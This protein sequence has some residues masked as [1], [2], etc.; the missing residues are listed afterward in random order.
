MNK[1]KFITFEG[2]EGAGKTTQI[3][4]LQQKL[5]N[6]GVQI[7]VTREP[8]G[9][10]SAE[11]LR[12]LVV[13][14]D[15]DDWSAMAELLIITAGRY[16]HVQNLILPALE[17]GVWV[18]SDRFYDSSAVYQGIAGGLGLEKVRRIQQEVLGNFAPDLTLVFDLPPA[19]GLARAGK[20]EADT[21][22]GEDRFER[23]GSQFHENLRQGYLQIAEAESRCTALDATQSIDQIQQV[24]WSK[25]E[26]LLP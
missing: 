22:S 11:K 16:E 6:H 25:V 17:K 5:E 24:I 4:L 2:G 9:T 14:G 15:L 12:D 18:I 8:G 7:L 3:K 21:A 13:K 1:G 26:T 20:R 19:V 23:K 10:P